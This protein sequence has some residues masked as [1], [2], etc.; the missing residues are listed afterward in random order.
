MSKFIIHHKRDNPKLK[1]TFGLISVEN[2]EVDFIKLQK[3]VSEVILNKENLE[4]IFCDKIKD[5][6]D[7]YNMLKRFTPN[8][9][10]DD[11]EKFVKDELSKN[12][13]FYSF[14]AE[15]LLPIVLKDLYNYSLT[16][17]VISLNDTLIDGHTGTD[18]CLYGKTNNVIV[19]GESKFYKDVN[20]GINCI[21]DDFKNEQGFKNKIDKF[22]RLIENNRDSKSIIIKQLNKTN[23]EEISYK[24]FLSLNIMY[25]GFVLHEHLV[26][27]HTY[28]SEK[29]YD[30][31]SISYEDISKNLNSIFDIDKSKLQHTLYFFHLPVS[32]KKELITMVI[33]NAQS[34]MEDLRNGNLRI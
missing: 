25:T 33:E 4:F 12:V 20:N 18:S 7:Y 13:N 6:E 3:Y 26:Q 21:I 27:T 29:F 31:F 10:V 24:E 8:K 22:K 34:I 11:L 32:S 16:S 17:S 19:F 14:F 1:T 2:I 28:F 9:K 15:A 23:L 30:K 5:E